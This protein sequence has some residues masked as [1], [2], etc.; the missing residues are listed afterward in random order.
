[1]V[2]LTLVLLQGCTMVFHLFVRNLGAETLT[3]R[4]YPEQP[5]DFTQRYLSMAP[6][7]LKPRFRA[8]R[9]LTDSVAVQRQGS[10][11]IV[12]LPPHSTVLLARYLTHIPAVDSV[13]L[14]RHGHPAQ[15]LDSLTLG[16]HYGSHLN[17]GGGEVW[18]DFL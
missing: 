14:E 1:L 6:Q 7:V 5:A 8:L 16:R 4:L 10:A 9:Q 11:L 12:T 18:L 3:L 15:V 17:L 2:L 13:R